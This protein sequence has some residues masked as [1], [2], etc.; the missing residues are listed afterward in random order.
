MK[1]IQVGFLMSYDYEM[2][3]KSIPP[4][5]SLSDNIFIALDENLLT[6]SGGNFE[7]DQ[8]FFQ[9]IREIDVDNKITFYRANFYEPGLT[10]ME[11]EIQ[12]RHKLA[13]KMG[14]GNWLIQIDCDEYFFDFKNFVADLRKN[15]RYLISPEKTPVQIAA[16]LV[17]L[18]KYVDDG[19][20]YVE[21]PLRQMMATN[22]PGYKV[23]RNTRQRIIYTENLLLH[24][25][26]SRTEEEV[27][28]KFRNWG[29]SHQ[30]N[31]EEFIGKWK[32]VNKEN[33]QEQ[34]DLFYMEPDKWK[35][36]NFVKGNSI[37]EI[38]ENLNLTELAPSEFFLKKKNFGQWFKF[39][40]K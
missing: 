1:K 7:V 28:T 38:K 37:Q 19:V 23:G 5:Y 15:D 11:N 21:K 18:Y 17:N 39:L 31:L 20:L 6:W 2:L 24:E 9:W 29:H 16:F 36:L 26:V 14:I 3:R 35:R 34:E 8:S 22:Y 10:A 32:A 27:T 4:V 33:F 40:W 12:E 13:L 25:C 30:V